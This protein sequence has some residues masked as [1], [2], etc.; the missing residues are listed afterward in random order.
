[1]QTY[2]DSYQATIRLDKMP[3]KRPE[4]LQCRPGYVQRGAACQKAT[5]GAKGKAQNSTKVNAGGGAMK[6]LLAAAAITGISGA[7]VATAMK[8]DPQLLDK[9]EKKAAEFGKVLAKPV[10]KKLSKSAQEA[11]EKATAQIDKKLDREPSRA[12]KIARQFAIEGMSKIFAANVGQLAAEA[13]GERNSIAGIVTGLAVGRSVRGWARNRLTQRFGDTGLSPKEKF[14]VTVATD[15]ALNAAMGG[16]Y[17]GTRPKREEENEEFAAS[18][19]GPS[20]FGGNQQRK[21]SSKKSK[22]AEET[23]YWKR[24]QEWR[25]AAERGRGKAEEARKKAE[26]ARQQAAG[27]KGADKSPD[28]QSWSDVLGVKPN[29]SPEE[30]KSAYRKMAKKYHPDVNKDPKAAEKFRK[31]QE[32]YEKLKKDGLSWDDIEY[33]YQSAKKSHPYVDPTFWVTFN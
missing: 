19:N 8:K 24:E 12:R 17:M 31:I 3:R 28:G 1:M 13:T 22:E 33:A 25:E 32:A 11:V 29:A 6:S 5:P 7:A 23:P 2:L 27:T 20:N 18:V 21:S 10:P 14:A 4:K 26:Q 15:L 30:I 9:V 16:L